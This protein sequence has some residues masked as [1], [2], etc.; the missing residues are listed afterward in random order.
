MAR[1]NRMPR[2]F[3]FAATALIAIGVG[4][5]FS[6]CTTSINGPGGAGG[7]GG[8]NRGAGGQNSSGPH[9]SSGPHMGTGGNGQCVPKPEICNGIDDNCDGQIDEGDPGGGDP[10]VVTSGGDN[11]PKGE[12]AKGVTHCVSGSIVCVPNKPSPEICDGLDNNCDGNVDEGDPGGGASC[13]TGLLGPC[14]PGTTSCVNGSLKC[15]GNYKPVPEIKCNGI[16]DDCNG[17]VDD[18][19]TTCCTKTGCTCC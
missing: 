19:S 9:I 5:A 3:L 4:A 6:A 11:P 2:S 13:D 15:V 8:D 18:T 1:L 10:C 17:V 14:A 16:D 12:C 7:D